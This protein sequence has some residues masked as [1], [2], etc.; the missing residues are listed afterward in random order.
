VCIRFP[1]KSD[2]LKGKLKN[3]IFLRQIWKFPGLSDIFP[4]EMEFSR[5]KNSGECCF[6]YL[7]EENR[8]KENGRSN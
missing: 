2:I 1:G 6:I 3:G 8:M 7:P 5:K 4:W